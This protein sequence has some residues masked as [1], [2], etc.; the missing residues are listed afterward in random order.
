[1]VLLVVGRLRKDCRHVFAIFKLAL[2]IEFP[3]QTDSAIL[4][5]VTILTS[6]GHIS[7]LLVISQKSR[8]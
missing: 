2:S 6:Q 1:M 4:Y 5:L 7:E 3:L 8:S